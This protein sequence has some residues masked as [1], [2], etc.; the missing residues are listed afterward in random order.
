MLPVLLNEV[1]K[2]WGGGEGGTIWYWFEG[3]ILIHGR[4]HSVNIRAH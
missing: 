1:Q 2:T 3:P 4:K